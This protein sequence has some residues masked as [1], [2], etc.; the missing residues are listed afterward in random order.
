M[1]AKQQYN[2]NRRR[3]MLQLLLVIAIVVLLNILLSSFFYR[4]D[5]TEEKRY[6]LSEPTKDLLEQTDDIVYIKIYLDGDLTPN[7]KKL[8]QSTVEII[9]QFRNYGKDNIQYEIINP[10]EQADEQNLGKYLKDLELEGVYSIPFGETQKEQSSR[11]FLFPYATITYH[12]RAMSV[13]LLDQLQPLSPMYDASVAISL[14]EYKFTK[15]IRLLTTDVKPKIAFIEGHNEL[16]TMEVQDIAISLNELYEVFRY[17]LPNSDF[18]DTTYK[19]I[20]VAKPRNTFSDADKYKI[21]QYIMYGGSV[22][23]LIDPVMAEFDSLRNG[24]EF[25]TYDYPLNIMD[26]LIQYGARINNN[27]IQD[28]QATKIKVPYANTFNDRPWIYNPVLTNFNKQSPIVKN[29]DAIEGKFVSTVDT[30]QVPGITKTVLISTSNLSRYLTNPAR[31]SYNVVQYVPTDTQMNKPNLP[32][33]ILL[34]GKFPSAFKARQQTAREMMQNRIG[35]GIFKEESVGAKQIFIGDGDMIR[36]YVDAKGQIY[37]LGAN[38]VEQY[39][40]GNKDFLMNC[41]E[42]LCDNTGMMET[43]A[44]EIKLRPINE[45][46]ANENRIQWQLINIAAPVILI[47]LFSGIYNYIRSRKYTTD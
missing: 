19:T 18:I 37:P 32:V 27:I 41:I 46:A 13:S 34:E 35:N 45:A 26:Q 5:L 42:Y 17:D 12:D 10:F 24:G 6:S 43:R 3:S 2:K 1:E 15:G 22:L 44:K 7:L 20:I 47:Y 33:A 16:D 40:F 39:V 4:I 9:N 8:Q 31:I 25:M 11:S 23:W 29:V 38:N 21:D 14:L 30:T 28:K 36:N